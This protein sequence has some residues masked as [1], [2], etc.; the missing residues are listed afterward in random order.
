MAKILREIDELKSKEC[1]TKEYFL[2]QCKR[3][4]YIGIAKSQFQ[5]IMQAIA[6]D[7]KR[8]VRVQDALFQ[9]S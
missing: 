4:C 3:A 8:L 2:S 9:G 1:R 5:G 7:F 6:H